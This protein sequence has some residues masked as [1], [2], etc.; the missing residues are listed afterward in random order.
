MVGN[1]EVERLLKSGVSQVEPAGGPSVAKSGF[2][3]VV[4]P[5]PTGPLI[6]TSLKTGPSNH[7][8]NIASGEIATVS[9]LVQEVLRSPGQP[10]DPATRAFMEPRFDHDFGHVRMHTDAKAADSARVV[11][12]HAYTMGRNVVFGQNE[13]APA[14]HQGRELLAHELAHTIQQRNPSRTPASAD[15][16]EVF[17]ASASAAAR[18][19]INGGTVVR[20]LPACG[21]QIQRAPDSDPKRDEAARKAAL[22]QYADPAWSDPL[23]PIREPESY[24]PKIYNVGVLRR[25]ASERKFDKYDQMEHGAHGVIYKKRGSGRVYANDIAAE[26]YKE[27]TERY[28]I[29][30]STDPHRVVLPVGRYAYETVYE[31]KLLKKVMEENK[32]PPEA[33]H[34]VAA[35]L[36]A[37]AESGEYFTAAALARI[38]APRVAGKVAGKAPK[39]TPPTTTT[40]KEAP[41]GSEPVPDRIVVGRGEKTG[42]STVPDPEG[43]TTTTLANKSAK[44]DLPGFLQDAPKDYP[45][46]VG[47]IKEMFLERMG[48]TPVGSRAGVN[49]EGISSARQ[50]LQPGGR[51]TILQ[52]PT[53]GETPAQVKTQLKALLPKTEWGDIKFTDRGQ[54]GVLVTAKKL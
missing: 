44:P 38:K 18:N 4:T 37:E 46:L 6:E 1:R 10:L 23:S 21:L 13:F 17:E 26:D 12:A 3:P 54:E 51:L 32:L 14:T 5:L 28:G 52:Q 53:A 45:H 47:K 25:K 27:L 2:Q 15:S 24:D 40:P 42:R 9:P 31:G 50:L 39:E 29:N 48:L 19:V 34:Q 43:M 8:G 36:E 16:Q 7:A 49:P 41:A 33:I 30:V 22:R 35:R 20:N 11:C